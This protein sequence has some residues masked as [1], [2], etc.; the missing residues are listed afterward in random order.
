[1]YRNQQVNRDNYN[2]NG[3]Y[4]SSESESDSDADAEAEENQGDNE[5]EDRLRPANNDNN[6]PNN[7]D[8]AREHNDILERI[9]FLGRN[10]DLLNVQRH[11]DDA[12]I[13]NDAHRVA[14]DENSRGNFELPMLDDGPSC[15]GLNLDIPASNVN[16][17]SS[18]ESMDM[19]DDNGRPTLGNI[20]VN[21]DAM[22]CKERRDSDEEPLGNFYGNDE[23]YCSYLAGTD[24]MN[25][26][27]CSKC[28]PISSTKKSTCGNCTDSNCCDKIRICF[29][30]RAMNDMNERADDANDVNDLAV[31][32]PS[33]AS[34]CPKDYSSDDDDDIEPSSKRPK[35]THCDN[36]RLKLTSDSDGG[37][38]AED[39]SKENEDSNCGCANDTEM[40]EERDEQEPEER[41]EIDTV[42]NVANADLECTC[43]ENKLDHIN[44]H[45]SKMFLELPKSCKKCANNGDD[46][47]NKDNEE[48]STSNADAAQSNAANKVDTN[49]KFED[50]PGPSNEPQAPNAMNNVRQRDA[51]AEIARPSK[52]AKL[53]S[54]IIANKPKVPR[55]I[56][57]K[58][59]DAV[60]MTWD[61]QHLKNIL[62]SSQYC[63][64]SPNA[65]QTPGT[66]ASTIIIIS[67]SKANFN[68]LGQPLWHE[69]L[70]MC[71]A[72][73][74]SLRS[75]GHTDA[76][77]R[78]SISVVRTM[79]QIQKDGQLLWNRYQATMNIQ[80]QDEIN[81]SGSCCCSNGPSSRYSFLGN[82]SIGS[83][84]SKHTNGGGS[85]NGAGNN[86]GGNDNGGGGGSG[87]NRHRD[88]RPIEHNSRNQSG[89]SANSGYM[90][91][92]ASR[93]AYK[94]YRYDYG[95]GHSNSYR[96]GM[97]H[98]RCKRCLDARERASYSNGYH[99]GRLN[100]GGNGNG[101]M[102][103]PIF[104]GNFGPMGGGSMY[105][106]RFGSGHFGGPIGYGNSRFGG[107]NSN[108][109]LPNMSH[110]SACHGDNCNLKHRPHGMLPGEYHNNPFGMPRAP[111]HDYMGNSNGY[112]NAIGHQC[113]PN[114]ARDLG[115]PSHNTRSNQHN[116]KIIEPAS[117]M[118]NAS[119]RRKEPST[120]G[121]ASSSRETDRNVDENQ[122]GCSKDIAKPSTSDSSAKRP[123]NQHTKNQCCIKNY[124]C[125]MP[126]SMH[127]KPKCC[128][129]SNCSMSSSSSVCGGFGSNFNNHYSAQA[130]CSTNAGNIY[131]GRNLPNFT[132][133]GNHRAG[134]DDSSN[135]G[136]NRS[137]S[138]SS[139]MS[140][141]NNRI[142]NYGAST[143]KASSTSNP[144]VEFSR[145]QKQNC[146]SNCLDCVIGCEIEFPLEAAACIFD[147][148]TEACITPDSINGSDMGRLTF[149]SV[150]GGTADDGSSIMSPRYQHVP[151]PNSNDRNETYLTLAFEVIIL[152]IGKQRPLP[153]GMNAQKIIPNQHDQLIHRLR[154]ID[155][156]PLLIN[157]LK[158]MAQLLL[159]GG[160][161]SGLGKSTLI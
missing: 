135:C 70:S 129:I 157:V 25:N 122:P 97:G 66:S 71:A 72:R 16:D 4:D 87:S 45:S 113:N 103:S 5:N 144:T 118:P 115:G 18:R 116:C 106:H 98:E 127:D 154:H 155:Q 134:K 14:F 88:R 30:R 13:Q 137:S 159:D 91:S 150:T 78:L 84:S 147:C 96:Y 64:D 59:L 145:K 130:S 108:N 43:F 131:F 123:C 102:P 124:C 128:S 143:S 75:H 26:C 95:G 9:D 153:Q 73:I 125:K 10:D 6:L 101:G 34:M 104:P 82:D 56:F 141:S 28:C 20:D 132:G 133:H 38:S 151:V 67:A 99:S 40:D 80:I 112:N 120:S 86:G 90:S 32:G 111:C 77:L 92:S 19:D 74:D 119:N 76:A 27:K 48:P 140:T 107:S 139:S 62:A 114:R 15:S 37:A 100:M 57:H 46:L 160:P 35:T 22:K 53:S 138:G 41:E 110:S 39:S 52:R 61:N 149:D 31:A 126:S 69:P 24:D 17:D 21:F 36:N 3:N 63:A 68:L 54:N 148:L 50:K 152:A 93:D 121:E 33:S 8:E 29:K 136:C 7:D 94:M 58:A 156:D 89:Y 12:N 158:Q 47:R 79:K 1:M 51:D 42:E 23:D 146:T 81:R 85:S 65:V 105:G 161:S 44:G 11:D 117:A 49:N 83:G 60:N 55:T 109:Y 2:N 142:V